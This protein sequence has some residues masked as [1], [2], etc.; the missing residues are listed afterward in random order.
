[1]SLPVACRRPRSIFFAALAP[2]CHRHHYAAVAHQPPTIHPSPLHALG[3][4]VPASWVFVALVPAVII[5][6][7]F[8]FDHGVSSLMAQQSKF[9]LKRCGRRLG[10]SV[11]SRHLFWTW[12]SAAVHASPP[13]TL[14]ASLL[15]SPSR[16]CAPRLNCVWLGRA[17]G[18]CAVPG[19]VAVGGRGV[20]VGRR[21]A[22]VSFEH[23]ARLRAR[24]PA[25]SWALLLAYATR[26]RRPAEPPS[27]GLGF[28][29]LG[30]PTHCTL[31]T[32]SDT[33]PVYCYASGGSLTAMTCCCWRASDPHLRPAGP[34]FNNTP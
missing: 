5:T 33:F 22:L 32:P 6:L 16:P 1:M 4:Q 13:L 3:P 28:R 19:R 7:L 24:P 18:V 11:F 23:R 34:P 21:C 10:T 2:G 29:G 17:F 26:F 9:G 27:E 15:A 14:V 8:W 25:Y 12:R 31:V 30:V 20:R